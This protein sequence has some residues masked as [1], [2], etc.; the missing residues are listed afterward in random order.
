MLLSKLI[1]DLSIK[2]KETK[3]KGL[4]LN[5]KT[6]KKGYMFFAVKG[7]NFNGE[8]FID[9]AIRRG[10]V[11]IVCSNRCKYKHKKIQIIK[12]PDIRYSISEISSKFYKLKPKNIVAVT[13][14][15]G[16]TSVADLFLQILKLKKK[17]LY[18]RSEHL[19]LNSKKK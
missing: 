19:E 10:A 17:F 9:E 6:V 18:L 3:I 1:K 7:G 12:T 13:G 8:K 11:A 2:N 15:N 4:S 5:S 16:K 14:T